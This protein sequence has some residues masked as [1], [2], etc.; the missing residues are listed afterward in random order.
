MK[1]TLI[2]LLVSLAVTS[3]KADY[4]IQFLTYNGTFSNPVFDVNGTTPLAGSAF[5]GQLYTGTSAGSLSAIGAATAFLP[6]GAG[7]GYIEAVGTIAQPSGSIFGGT[8]GFYQLRV[9]NAAG[10]ANYEIASATAGAKIGSSAVTAV[11]FGGSPNGGGAPITP[12]QANLHS[13]FA[14]STVAVPEPASLALGLFG[15]AGLLFRRRK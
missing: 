5:L 15:A 6:L 13:S 11:T 8:A 3:A 1:K 7:D 9:W 10:G 2:A 14:L 4:Q 12:P